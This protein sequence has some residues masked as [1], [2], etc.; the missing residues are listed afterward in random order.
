MLTCFAFLDWT[1]SRWIHVVWSQLDYRILYVATVHFMFY[2]GDV[3]R[4]VAH[5]WRRLV[6]AMEAVQSCRTRPS[7]FRQKWSTS[8]YYNYYNVY[9]TSSCGTIARVTVGSQSSNLVRDSLQTPAPL[10]WWRS[11]G[12]SRY[13]NLWSWVLLISPRGDSPPRWGAQSAQW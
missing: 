2:L 3:I 1:W 4:E 11:C 13:L 5:D 9:R 6:G 7:P 10:V 12:M 8:N